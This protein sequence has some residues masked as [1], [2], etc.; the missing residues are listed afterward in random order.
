[1]VCVELAG[2]LKAHRHLAGVIPAMGRR[3]V[4]C[5][6]GATGVGAPWLEIQWPAY[7]YSLSL[8]ETILT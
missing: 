6:E 4:L 2:L 1:M 5:L 3:Q 7:F 8:F